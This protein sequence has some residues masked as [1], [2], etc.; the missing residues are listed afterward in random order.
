MLSSGELAREHI[1]HRPQ[2]LDS[3]CVDAKL[4]LSMFS[5]AKISG[6]F[7]IVVCGYLDIII[8]QFH[9]APVSD[10]CSLKAFLTFFSVSALPHLLCG[11][12]GCPY[13]SASDTVVP[14]LQ[15]WLRV[16]CTEP[17]WI[18]AALLYSLFCEKS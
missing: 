2:L 16:V 9:P 6:L 15:A 7:A 8:Q 4:V 1:N 18:A 14:V 3:L 11:S 12:W 10:I 5:L 17:C 13:I